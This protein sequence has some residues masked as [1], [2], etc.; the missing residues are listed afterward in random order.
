MKNKFKN[1]TAAII[2]FG[3]FLV[4]VLCSAQV[5]GNTVNGGIVS[6]NAYT[7]VDSYE[8]NGIFYV[9]L[10]N[11][12]GEVEVVEEEDAQLSNIDLQNMLQ[13]QQQTIQMLSNISKVLHDTA[14]AVVR[15]I[16]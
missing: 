12:W 6:G 5:A 16:G 10:R 2:I 15:K 14:K 7:I 13:K 9:V 8:Q 11:P 1:L 4:P 3:I